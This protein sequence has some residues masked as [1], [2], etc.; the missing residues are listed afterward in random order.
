LSGQLRGVERNNVL[1]LFARFGSSE[2]FVCLDQVRAEGD[3]TDG[4]DR[5]QMAGSAASAQEG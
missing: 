1:R 4:H 2:R 3:M 5:Y